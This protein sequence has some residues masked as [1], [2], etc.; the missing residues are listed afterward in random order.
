[1]WTFKLVPS[2]VANAPSGYKFASSGTALAMLAQGGSVF[3]VELGFQDGNPSTTYTASLL[4]NG[5]AMGL[6][7]MTTNRDGGAELHA[8]VQVDPG[9]YLL[10]VV[11]F[12]VSDVSAFG[13]SG[14]VPVL[15]SSPSTQLA[16]VGPSEEYQAGS[17]GS[18]SASHSSFAVT[19]TATTLSEGGD[20]EG[21]IKSAVGDLTI[22]ATIQVTPLASSTTVLD[23]RFSVSVGQLVG[24][25]LVIAV[26]GENVTGPRVI[27]I[28]M[29]KTAPLSL[30][31]ELNVTLDGVPVAEASS[32]LQVL[33]PVATN[34]PMYVLVSTSAS[35][36]LLVSI[37]HFSL[38]LLQVA[39]VI[40]HSVVNSLELDAPVLLGSILV[41]TLAF[42][43][44]YASRKRY[45]SVLI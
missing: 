9:A 13:A 44:A 19:R 26:S 17:T 25:G 21:Q 32:T 11:V 4:L 15:V 27:M 6:G 12:D 16:V 37:P 36:Q 34:P 10:G 43:A 29:S 3:K 31:P 33:N 1:M 20:V 35:I 45:Y 14:P 41:V 8:T 24:N 28:N 40:L 7:T 22:P 2:G 5:T 23:S 39:G 30:Y 38:H 42:A 18:S